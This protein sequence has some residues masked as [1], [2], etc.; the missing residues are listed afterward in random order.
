MRKFGSEEK[1]TPSKFHSVF[2]RPRSEAMK[3]NE[4]SEALIKATMNMK[5]HL[6]N[7]RDDGKDSLCTY[8]FI[9]DKMKNYFLFQK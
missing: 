5:R 3:C 9:G 1:M 4:K 2:N 8:L 7:A 6:P